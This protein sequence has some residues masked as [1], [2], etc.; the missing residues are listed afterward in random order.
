MTIKPACKADLKALCEIENEAFD[1][2]SYALSCKNFLYH[3]GKN[4]LFISK[5]DDK[6]AGYILLLTRK[7]SS[8]ARIYS[9][10]VK[11]EFQQQGIGKKLLEESFAW[12]K[13]S[14]KKAVSLE[15]NAANFSAVKLYEKAGFVKIKI[16]ANYYPDGANAIRM[17]KLLTK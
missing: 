14:G 6:I 9:I 7:K 10:A 2:N 17:E 12:T 5:I 8:K 16:L 3:I 4:Q 11:K 13:K 1:K 15:V